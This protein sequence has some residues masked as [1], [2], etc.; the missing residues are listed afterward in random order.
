MS[1]INFK[2]LYQ[3]LD[4]DGDNFSLD[5]TIKTQLGHERSIFISG[6]V[7]YYPNVLGQYRR[8]LSDYE[9]YVDG[10]LQNNPNF[11]WGF[12]N[13][14]IH[15]GSSGVLSSD[16][17]LVQQALDGYIEVYNFL[18]QNYPQI[19]WGN[20]NLPLRR[21]SIGGT[22]CTSSG[23]I[24]WRT[25]TGEQREEHYAC[26]TEKFREISNYTDVYVLSNYDLHNRYAYA[27]GSSRSNRIQEDKLFFKYGFDFLKY[28]MIETRNYKPCI[29]FIYPG[30]VPGNG[31]RVSNQQIEPPSTE[32]LTP[33]PN[34]NDITH[35]QGYNSTGGE[36]GRGMYSFATI[37][38]DEWMEEIVIPHVDSGYDGIYLWNEFDSYYE[39]NA[40]STSNTNEQKLWR[41]RIRW[42]MSLENSFSF[43]PYIAP[44]PSDV[45]EWQ[46]NQ[47]EIVNKIRLYL[48]LKNTKKLND[49]RN[50]AM[51]TRFRRMAKESGLISIKNSIN[52]KKIGISDIKNEAT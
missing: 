27:I 35:G 14:E 25:S 44:D 3:Y 39:K 2:T 16:P 29:P 20:Y 18:K 8:D 5:P 23:G 51:A 28:L 13:L 32:T 48:K 21:R 31:S 26:L 24:D 50:Y 11:E 1:N 12:L 9:I 38:D 40:K 4:G 22:P 41:A 15:V 19:K 45:Q 46:D 33:Y 17:S 10:Q 47:N 52:K 6:S 36:Y 42:L 30:Y 7:G 37:D 43:D 49:I 34:Y